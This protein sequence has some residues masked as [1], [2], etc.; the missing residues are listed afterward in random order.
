[1]HIAVAQNTFWSQ[2]VENT[3]CSEVEMSKKWARLWREAHWQVKVVKNWPSRT[4]FGRW[5]VEKVHAVVEREAHS[6]VKS[7]K[8]WPSRTTFLN[9]Q[10]YKKLTLTLTLAPTTTATAT[11]ATTTKHYNIPNITTTRTTLQLQLQLQVKLHYYILHESTL[12]LLHYTN[13]H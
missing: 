10:M 9:V 5:N 6:Q 12:H 4:T 2:N 7:V 13:I 11:A 3:S 1:M 8:S